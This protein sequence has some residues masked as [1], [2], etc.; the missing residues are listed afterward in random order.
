MAS[1]ATLD[2]AIQQALA[3]PGVERVLVDLSQVTFL[4]S[5][6]INTLVQ[7]HQ[8][9]G[10]Q[11]VNLQ[12]VNPSKMA[13]RVLNLTGV[14]G[15]LSGDAWGGCGP[16]RG[17]GTCRTGAGQGRPATSA[18][19][20]LVNFLGAPGDRRASRRPITWVRSTLWPWQSVCGRPA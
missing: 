7:G 8:R 20:P 15:Y 2:N 10:D 19:A 12:V 18:V 1:S 11:N 9:A 6:G 13:L 3:A 16:V 5:T 17:G 14:I 4:D